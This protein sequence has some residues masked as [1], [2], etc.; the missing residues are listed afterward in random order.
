M[1]REFASVRVEPGHVPDW[2]EKCNRNLQC[3]DFLVVNDSYL[4]VKED[5]SL[6][7]YGLNAGRLSVATSYEIF[8]VQ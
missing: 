4:I 7:S 2:F 3:A 8:V 1:P 6:E 5:K